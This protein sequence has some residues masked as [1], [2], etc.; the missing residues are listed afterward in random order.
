MV[1]AGF[2]SSKGALGPATLLFYAVSSAKNK[3]ELAP[4][5]N[6]PSSIF[7]YS[8][9]IYTI[10]PDSIPAAGCILSSHRLRRQQ[11]V[12]MK[13]SSAAHILRI[14][15]GSSEFCS[16]WPYW[17]Q[18]SCQDPQDYLFWE[19]AIRASVTRGWI[20]FPYFSFFLFLLP[21]PN[22]LG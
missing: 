4:F 5:P 19:G 9:H 2:L 3:G 16:Q 14:T 18:Q 11:R 12:L 8:P 13:S 17:K 6:S 15:A 10:T 7:Q 21:L 22:G 20:F 1:S